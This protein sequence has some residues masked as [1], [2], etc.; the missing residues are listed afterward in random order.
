[1]IV[2]YGVLGTGSFILINYV[3]L[4]KEGRV[5]SSY[6]EITPLYSYIYAMQ[7]A[8]II[9]IV[10]DYWYVVAIYLIYSYNRQD[11]TKNQ[12]APL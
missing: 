11:K 9:E 10:F 4:R 8:A 7:V 3:C 1:M 2:D 5:L 12:T 6:Q